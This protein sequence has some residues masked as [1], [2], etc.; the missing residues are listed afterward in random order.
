MDAYYNGIS[1]SG[2]DLLSKLTARMNKG[3]K[4]IG[5]EGLGE[6]YKTTDTLPDG[7]IHDYYSNATSY[8]PSDLNGGNSYE[9]ASFNK[10]HSIPKSWWGGSKSNQGCDVYIVVPTDC[11]VNNKR[12]NYSFG[13]TSG[14]KWK[15]KNGY[16]KL[17]AS[18]LSG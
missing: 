16:C 7:H 17:G 4:S 8:Y 3:F 10:E 5:Y 9:G 15:S 18:L 2:K 12:S 14:E 1:G 13:E 11:Y 6:A